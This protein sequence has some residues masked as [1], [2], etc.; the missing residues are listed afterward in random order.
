MQALH[1]VEGRKSYPGGASHISPSCKKEKKTTW[2]WSKMIKLTVRYVNYLFL[3]NLSI[4]YSYRGL[5]IIILQIS[6]LD[7]FL[8]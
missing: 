6:Y 4:I 7:T 3:Y 1:T 8:F 5:I 2:D